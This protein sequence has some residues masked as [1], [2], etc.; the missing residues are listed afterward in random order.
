[1][2]PEDQNNEEQGLLRKAKDATKNATK[3]TVN[4]AIKAL[5][6]ALI[7]YAPIILAAALIIGVF[8]AAMHYNTY[9][10]G[11]DSVSAYAVKEVLKDVNPVKGEH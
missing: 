4:I 9:F 7:H 8:S 10:N 3:K 11:N 2:E 6:A 1:M 5:V